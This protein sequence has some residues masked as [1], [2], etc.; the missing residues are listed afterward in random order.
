MFVTRLPLDLLE[1]YL[2]EILYDQHD[3]AM[4][5][6]EWHILLNTLFLCQVSVAIIGCMIAGRWT[7]QET[8]PSTLLV[9]QFYVLLFVHTIFYVA[10]IFITAVSIQYFNM[11]Y[12]IE[13]INILA[14]S[15]RRCFVDICGNLDGKTHDFRTPPPSLLDARTILDL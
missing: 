10:E 5:E 13:C 14:C 4:F 7:M 2:P 15:S 11:V 8:K 6:E 1:A 12:L 3:E 9:K